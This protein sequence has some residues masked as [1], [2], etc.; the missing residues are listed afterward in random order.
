MCLQ[1][2]PAPVEAA[3]PAAVAAAP[4]AAAAAPVAPAAPPPP[5]TPPPGP[6][7]RADGRVIAT[8]YAK[9]LAKKHRVDLTK[10]GGTGP[11]GRITASDVERAAGI[12]SVR[13]GNGAAPAPAAPAAAVRC[14]TSCYSASLTASRKL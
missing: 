5:P 1:E 14:Y 7:P 12:P 4:A 2:A 6:A 8:P 9:L 11:N 13:G 3:A 10:L